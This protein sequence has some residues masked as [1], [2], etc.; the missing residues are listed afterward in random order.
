MTQKRFKQKRFKLE[1]IG[2]VYDNGTLIGM[3][4]IVELLNDLHEENQELRM[5]NDIKFWKHECIRESNTNTIFALELGKAIDEGY[6]V[7]EKFKQMM[8]EWKK[9]TEEMNEKHQR[10]FE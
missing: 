1:D 3:K 10:L 2:F 9:E 8:E 7:S 6:V 5:D 4:K